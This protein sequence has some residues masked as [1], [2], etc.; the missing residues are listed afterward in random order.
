[1][2][3]PI[4]ARTILSK[5]R[6]GPDEWFGIAYSMNVYRGCLHAC[7]YC[8]TRSTCYKIG[9]LS[10]I[11]VKIN[12]PQLLSKE[13]RSKKQKVTIGTGSMNDPYM[14]PEKD[15]QVVRKCL[16][17]IAAFQFPVHVMTKSSLITRDTDILKEIGK[18]YVAASFTI[19][20]ATD[21]LS[22][23]LEPGAP[24]TSERLKAMEHL[25]KH[26]IYC[27]V[28]MMPVLPFINDNEENVK[29]L[30]SMAA[31]AGASYIMP[32]FGLT[33]REGQREYFH[34]QLELQFPGIKEKYEMKF[35]KAY[36]CNSPLANQLYSLSEELSDKHQIPLKMK[37]YR[38]ANPGN[39]MSMFS[40]E[41]K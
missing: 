36:T 26:G 40:D 2:V 15:L 4:Q 22:A 5:I 30:F 23:R 18:V 25:S 41:G 12:A 17:I 35:G 28:S 19:T 32:W 38:N 7:I 21:S 34:D 6:G 8:D 14:P 13:L 10:D 27:G 16:E 11:R 33:Q 24:V 1:M 20:S 29:E 39:Q 31:N 9:D 37:H 3:T